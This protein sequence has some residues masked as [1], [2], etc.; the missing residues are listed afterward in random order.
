M[1]DGAMLPVG[2]SFQVLDEAGNLIASY[3]LP[4][5]LRSETASRRPWLSA[6]TDGFLVGFR[7]WPFGWEARNTNGDVY[8]TA[9]AF[10]PAMGIE[11][12]D[13]KLSGLAAVAT[14]SGY[15]QVLADPRSDRRIL[16]R[17]SL[18][19]EWRANREIEVPLGFL[20]SRPDDALLLALR[21]TDR[22]EYVVYR[23][24]WHQPR[25]PENTTNPRRY[26]R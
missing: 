3:S 11:L 18:D 26:R 7:H 2:P 6:T 24:R 9:S 21:Q 5:A 12:R 10:P 20:H 17:Y 1:T 22:K 15:L 4:E 16:V 19:G 25:T 13:A 23:W 8:A 14:D